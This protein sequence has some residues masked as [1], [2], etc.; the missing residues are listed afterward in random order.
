MPRAPTTLKNPPLSSDCKNNTCSF[1]QMWPVFWFL[2]LLVRGFPGVSD[3]KASVC[4]AGDLRLILGLGRFPG[5]GNDNP[6]RYSC[7]ENPMDRGARGHK[8]SDA[9]ERLNFDFLSLVGEE[10]VYLFNSY[11][12]RTCYVPSIIPSFFLFSV[13]LKYNFHTMTFIHFKYT[14]QLYLVDLVGCITINIIRF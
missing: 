4:N 8:V 12:L 7:L 6:F 10:M 3:G 5:G 11:L 1:R 2:S 9:T 13:L 14:I